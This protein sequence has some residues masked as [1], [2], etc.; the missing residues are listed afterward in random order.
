MNGIAE[1]A[2]VLI[3]LAIQVGGYIGVG[4]LVEMSTSSPRVGTMITIPITRGP[5]H[6]RGR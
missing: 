1:L 6:P 4:V 2:P 5:G 3:I